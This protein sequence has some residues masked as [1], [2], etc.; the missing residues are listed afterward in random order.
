[1]TADS[2]LEGDKFCKRGSKYANVLPVPVGAVTI[3][4]LFYIKDGIT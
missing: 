3:M 2:F 4:F 1:M